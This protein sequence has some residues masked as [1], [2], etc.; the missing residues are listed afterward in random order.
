MDLDRDTIASAIVGTGGAWLLGSAV[1]H[2]RS[3]RWNAMQRRG[4]VLAGVGFLMS[5]VA[6]RWLQPQGNRGIAIALMGTVIAMRG[7]FI[8]VRERAARRAAEKPGT[9]E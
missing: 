6:A 9:R 1:L 2:S 3:D 4:L 5:A 7:M 8:L